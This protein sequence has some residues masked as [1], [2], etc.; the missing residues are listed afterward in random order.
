MTECGSKKSQLI[1]C[2]H[3]TDAYYDRDDA[4]EDDGETILA[5]LGVKSFYGSVY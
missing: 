4:R 1:R 2:P 3:C 5:E